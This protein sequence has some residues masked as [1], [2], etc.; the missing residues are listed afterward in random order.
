MILVFMETRGL[1]AG[2]GDCSLVDS[3]RIP[4]SMQGAEEKA[5]GRGFHSETVWRK[6]EWKRT[7]CCA[8]PWCSLCAPLV[9]GSQWVKK[10]AGLC[11][12]AVV[13]FVEHP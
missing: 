3:G 1:A 9:L 2:C 12:Q 4:Y 10:L 11:L 6:T 7:R 13:D 5:V 8:C